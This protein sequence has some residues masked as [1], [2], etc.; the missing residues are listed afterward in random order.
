MKQKVIQDLIKKK[1]SRECPQG[2]AQ[3]REHRAQQRKP[4]HQLHFEPQEK[5]RE[6][7]VKREAV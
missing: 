1:F 6:P 7:G 2:G 5:E 3:M 4:F